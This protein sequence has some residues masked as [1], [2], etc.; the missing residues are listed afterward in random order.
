MVKNYLLFV[1][2]S[3][4]RN[5]QSTIINIIGL[6]AGLCSA[7]I[8]AL[9]A[10]DQ[11]QYDRFHENADNIYRFNTRYGSLNEAVPLGPYPLNQLIDEEIPGIVSSLRIRPE[12]SND[13]WFRY[14]EEHFINQDFLLADSNFFTFFSF[15]LLQGD[16]HLVL[17]EPNSVVIDE[18]AARMIFGDNDP[19]G[20]T[21][22][23]QGM[24][25]VRI[26]GVMKDFPSHSHF[27]TSFVA[28]SKIARNYAPFLFENWETFGFYYYLHLDSNADV[29]TVAGR[30]NLALAEAA[31]DL[32]EIVNFRLQHLS[33]IRLHS[34]R[35]AWDID[36]QGNIAM[37]NG[38]IAAAIVILLLATA[39]YVN[40]Y[41]VQAT[42]RRK[43]IGIRK[44]MGAGQRHMFFHCMMESA[45]YIFASFII[46]LC[47][48]EILLPHFR[49][50]TGNYL[51]P[52]M[53]FV[54]PRWIWLFAVLL[55]ITFL[56]GFYPA[57]MVGR[58][59]PSHILKGSSPSGFFPGRITKTR[60]RTRQ[61]L[62]VFQFSCAIALIILS[63]SVGSQLRYMLE[64]DHGYR[65]SGLFVIYNPTGETRAARFLNLKNLLESFP[66]IELVTTGINVPSERLN[67]FTHIRLAE[68]ED[69]L[70]SGN[71]NV[72]EDYFAAL[73]CAVIA[74]RIF[75]RGSV[76][77]NRNSVVINRTA[78]RSLGK[79]PEE[80][81][82]SYL[83]VSFH[84]EDLQIIGVIEDIHFFS[85]HEMVSPMIFTC[86]DEWHRYE[87]ILV[88]AGDPGLVRAIGITRDIWEREYGDYPLNFTVIEDKRVQQYKREMQTRS[89]TG[90][91]MVMAIIISLMGLYSLSSFVMASRK[92]EIAL[93]K[94]LGADQANIMKM[95]MVE[96]S[97]LV[98][99]GTIIAW[100]VVWIVY[101]RWLENF[102]YRQDLNHI[103]FIAAP[104]IVL[105]AALITISYHTIR[106]ASANPVRALKCE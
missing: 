8:I 72:H 40:M 11:F 20:E 28:N 56:S 103:V 66:E 59:Q 51:S 10:L 34:G 99:S 1:I 86:N 97:L 49:D 21:I 55:F 102:A 94:V 78:A 82:G 54:F 38:L 58:L 53:M 47:L 69:E 68:D 35:I 79:L 27:K 93:R 52:V 83:H 3:F 105:A 37:L 62:T 64:Q 60:F 61:V 90:L 98:L 91:F 95:I 57:F 5:R 15:P 80:I 22:E 106:V 2:R 92:K 39:N 100:P 30:I 50:L 48:T 17:A 63:F 88:R 85:L 23:V 26:T 6:S 7:L 101:N 24:Y 74:G 46:A 43:E 18:S 76:D 75:G 14:G 29:P 19:L 42:A 31:P 71:I 41:T 32:A 77:G 12:R 44:V 84:D 9:Y 65:D 70:Q 33:D 87:K 25:P 81:I 96:F 73:G 4:I 104:L 16:P 13:F 36:N 89:I 45:A 67:N